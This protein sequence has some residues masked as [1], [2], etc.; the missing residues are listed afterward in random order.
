[1]H[2]G[3]EGM[4]QRAVEAVLGRMITDAEFRSRFLAAPALVC[5]DDDLGLTARETEA[6]LRVNQQRLDDIASALDPKIVRAT[7]PLEPAPSS[8]AA[9]TNEVRSL[10]RRRL[11]TVHRRD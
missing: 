8:G 11:A 1:M 5:R 7:I 4:S 6:L 10:P 3:S 9:Y 2:S